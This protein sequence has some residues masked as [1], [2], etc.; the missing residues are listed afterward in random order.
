V[1]R[2]VSEAEIEAVAR[3][4]AVHEVIMSFPEGYDTLV[5]EKGVTLSGGQKQ[6][7]CIART[8]LKNPPILIFDDA[9]SAVDT[10]TETQIH[11][12]LEQ[13]RQNRTTF[14]IAHRMQTVMRADKIL[15]LDKGRIVQQGSHA[16][17]MAQDGIYRRTYQLQAQ[18]EQELI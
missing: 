3:V 13:L 6:R 16:G 18:V 9:V 10:E 11:E 12:A 8:L 7:V 15:V 2:A 17:L 1:D 5:G 4:A 14:V